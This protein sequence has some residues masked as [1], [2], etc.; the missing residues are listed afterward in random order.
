ME[1]QI[2][3]QL[4]V[5][6][7]QYRSGQDPEANIARAYH[8]AK[9]ISHELPDIIVLP[10][11]TFF[12][13]KLSEFP[14]FAKNLDDTHPWIELLK[15]WSQEFRSVI[16][17]GSLP[18]LS[19]EKNKIYQTAAV[20]FPD[21]RYPLFFRKHILFHGIARHTELDES[22]VVTRGEH[23]Y[24]YFEV[25]GW[26][27]GLTLCVELRYSPI[28]HAMRHQDRCDVAIVPTSFYASTGK[29]HFL[30]LLRARAIEFQMYVISANQCTRP[31]EEKPVFIGQSCIIDPWGEV[32][33]LAGISADALCFQELA[34]EKILEIR[35]RIKM[36]E[37][38]LM[39]SLT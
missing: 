27:I 22:R 10:E 17:A 34:Q 24:L 18:E 2:S 3:Q 12:L 6:C 13:G 32:L 30:P 8:L 9:H 37:G 5:A 7:V 16:V 4:K 1:H 15:T 11:H 31:G 33:S 39:P 23:P 25:Q 28:F 38:P 35:S 29:D 36:G 26:R 19:S 20:I 14:N 21:K